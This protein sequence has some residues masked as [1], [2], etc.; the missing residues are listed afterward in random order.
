MIAAADAAG[1]LNVP[2][3]DSRHASRADG[4]RARS[5]KDQARKKKGN[6]R[7]NI[8]R[9]N[10]DSRVIMSE[11]LRGEI[12]ALIRRMRRERGEEDEAGG[13]LGGGGGGGGGGDRK[14]EGAK[15]S[16]DMAELGFDAQFV[17]AAV[18]A[19]HAAAYTAAQ[20]SKPMTYKQQHGACLDWLCMHVPE[21]L[22]P[23][24]FN[25]DG[26]NNEVH[27]ASARTGGDPLVH[28]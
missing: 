23:A 6:K 13:V 8:E 25:P 28:R 10:Q 18:S 7:E 17:Q 5:E 14:E 9:T 11:E 15:L 1:A 12:E 27:S 21:E 22:L 2:R 16:A 3:M 4:N 26:K 24:R 19:V 20:T